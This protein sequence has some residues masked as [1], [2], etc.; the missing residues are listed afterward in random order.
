M[1]I[2]LAADTE[3]W[4]WDETQAQGLHNELVHKHPD[5][6]QSEVGAIADLFAR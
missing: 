6:A 2:G 4:T 3:P 1:F 5:L